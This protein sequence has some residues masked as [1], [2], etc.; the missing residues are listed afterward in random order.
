MQCL[1]YRIQN[2]STKLHFHKNSHRWS[3]E[4][5]GHATEQA[6][7]VSSF[8]LFL[9]FVR[10]VKNLKGYSIQSMLQ[11][12]RHFIEL[13]H[14]LLSLKGLPMSTKRMNQGKITRNGKLYTEWLVIILSSKGHCAKSS[15]IINMHN[16]TKTAFQE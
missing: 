8:Y 10:D 7:K 3:C 6:F 12:R 15:H 1:A 16:R 14:N 4:H 5:H 11:I 13:C 2:L 9:Y